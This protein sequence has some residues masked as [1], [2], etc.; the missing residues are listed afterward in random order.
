MAQPDPWLERYGERRGA[1]RH[2]RWLPIALVVASLLALALAI[3]ALLFAS[4]RDAGWRPPSGLHAFRACTYGGRVEARCARVGGLHVA[5]IPATR[6]P[7][8]GALFYL[9]GGPGGA[10]TAAAVSVD[11]VFAK[12]SE[13]RDIVLVDQRGTGGSQGVA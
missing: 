11:S 2:T 10:A 6:Q 8:R 12:V 13:F 5:V 9:E 7:A 4:S 3:A 1:A